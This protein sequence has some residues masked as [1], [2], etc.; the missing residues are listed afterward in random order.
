MSDNRRF[1]PTGRRVEFKL[2]Y[3]LPDF[4]M[5]FNIGRDLSPR[6]MATHLAL[7]RGQKS[8]ETTG[9]HAVGNMWWCTVIVRV[10]N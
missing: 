3:G 2:V 10:V 8:I 1:V 6:I 9:N 5:N 4:N 7:P